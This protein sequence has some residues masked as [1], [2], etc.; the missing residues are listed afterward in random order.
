MLGKFGKFGET[1]AAVG[2]HEARHEF[3]AEPAAYAMADQPAFGEKPGA[4]AETKRRGRRLKHD[5]DAGKKRAAKLKN[6]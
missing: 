2:R 6:A 3:G 4:A 5:Q 1:I